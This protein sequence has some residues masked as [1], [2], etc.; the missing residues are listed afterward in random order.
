MRLGDNFRHT[1]RNEGGADGR[2]QGGRVSLSA[3]DRLSDERAACSHTA[4]GNARASAGAEQRD[5][6]RPDGRE[7]AGAKR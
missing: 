5:T 4:G 6:G 7:T 3:A 1:L 2:R